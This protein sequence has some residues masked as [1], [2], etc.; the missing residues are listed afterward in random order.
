MRTRMAA[1]RK[2]GIA[3]LTGARRPAQAQARNHLSARPVPDRRTACFGLRPTLRASR[4]RFPLRGPAADARAEAG[5]G[6]ARRSRSSSRNSAIPASLKNACR[7]RGACRIST[8]PRSSMVRNARDLRL[9][10]A[11][12]G[13]PGAAELPGGTGRLT[14]KLRR[15]RARAMTLRG[16]RRGVPDSR[17]RRR[18]ADCSDRS[19]PAVVFQLPPGRPSFSRPGKCAIEPRARVLQASVPR[20]ELRRRP[21]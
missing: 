12:P 18:H 9:S 2:T 4:P 16:V 14:R 5:A 19:Q 3:S 7:P 8:S 21:E 15:A 13:A 6:H 10:L 17:H 11:L 20:S 1:I